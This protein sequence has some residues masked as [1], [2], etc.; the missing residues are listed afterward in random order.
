MRTLLLQTIF[1]IALFLCI[2]VQAQST[3]TD[4]RDGRV[5]RTVT[6]GKQTWMAEN[7][8]FLPRI[9]KM[10]DGQFEIERY[11]VYG[12]FGNSLDAAKQTDAY[13]TYGVLYNWKGA[14]TSCPEGWHL[15]TD[16]EWQEMEMSLGMSSLDAESRLWRKSGD[17]GKKLISKDGWKKNFGSDETGFGALPGG[18]R[19]Y[20]GF[21]G[22]LYIA[23][24]WTSSPT[25]GD[26]GLRRGLLF[27]ESGIHKTEDRRYIGSSV[28]CVKN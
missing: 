16:A 15:P 21:E 1:L 27:D 22:D 14:C 7:L 8:A 10:E 12:Y 3:F 4:S 19:G 5:Y 25:N 23:F 17:V 13:K 9:D 24:F 11:W 6:I 28:R 26:N 18:C 2:P 20:N